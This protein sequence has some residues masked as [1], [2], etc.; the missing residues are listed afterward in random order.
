M[1]KRKCSQFQYDLNFFYYQ[2][3]KG[4][5]F[6]RELCGGN[7]AENMLDSLKN[8][9][10]ILPKT[11]TKIFN[12]ELTNLIPRI[13]IDIWGTICHGQG[14]LLLERQIQRVYCRIWKSFWV[15]LAFTI[16]CLGQSAPRRTQNHKTYSLIMKMKLRGKASNGNNL[17]L[18][19]RLE[20]RWEGISKLQSTYSS[21]PVMP[22]QWMSNSWI[23][24]TKPFQQLWRF[25]MVVVAG[26]PAWGDSCHN[27]KR[28]LGWKNKMEQNRICCF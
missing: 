22:R 20:S 5:I 26:Q 13:D 19:E 17:F 1:C 28:V 24:P 10:Q 2:C 14:R 6:I 12:V 7:F 8:T 25:G 27:F 3:F 9:C 4:I 23:W 15:L 18:S 16:N 21:G 11:K